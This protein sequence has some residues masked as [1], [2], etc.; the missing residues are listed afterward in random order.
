MRE[1]ALD[2]L[3]KILTSLL[4]SY[5]EL[6]TARP[7]DTASSRGDFTENEDTRQGNSSSS[8][9]ELINQFVQIKQQKSIIENG[10][11]L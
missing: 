9:L 5:E 7:F 8:N 6:S 4:V 1:I 11:D 3:V 10:I 2:C